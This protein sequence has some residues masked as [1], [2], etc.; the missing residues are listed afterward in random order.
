MMATGSIKTIHDDRGFGFITPD[1]ANDGNDLFFHHSAVVDEG[2]NAL[3]IGQR[4][5]YDEGTDPRNPTR[6]R[7]SKVEPIED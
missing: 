3:E 2:F 1:D 6:I 4:V 7:A 5:N